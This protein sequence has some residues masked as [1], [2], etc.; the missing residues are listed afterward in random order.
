MSDLSDLEAD[1]ARTRERLNS[2]IDR[3]QDKLTLTGMVDEVMGQTGMP[4]MADGHDLVRSLLRRHPIPLM[5]AAAG[6]GFMIYSIS[7]RERARAS[8]LAEID[9]IDVPIIN[10]GQARVYDP[11]RPE[12]HR[13]LAGRRDVAEA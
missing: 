8:R 5:V 11:D 1:V 4:V 7:R 9:E 3:I 13:A 6:I 2:T 12:S 10:V